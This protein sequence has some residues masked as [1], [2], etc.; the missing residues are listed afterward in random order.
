ME[1]TQFEISHYVSATQLNNYKPPVRQLIANA[2][3]MKFPDVL[4]EAI[5]N[6]G[7]KEIIAEADERL[8]KMGVKFTISI[9]IEPFTSEAE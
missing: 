5:N 6:D 9:T 2:I 8:A 4:R 1:K 7:V 3:S